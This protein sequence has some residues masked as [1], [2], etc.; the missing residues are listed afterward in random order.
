MVRTTS[1]SIVNGGGSGNQI[2][3][4]QNTTA[5]MIWNGSDWTAAGASSSTTLQSAYDNT[6][7]SAGGA[8]LIVSSGGNTNG[9][10]IRDST[11]NPV[12]GRLLTVQTSS[13]ADFI[14]VNSNVTEYA[15]D[16]G[17]EVA[18]ASSS[19]FPGSTWS[20]ISGATVS[21]YTTAGDNIATGQGS[22]SG[23][24]KYECWKRCQ[25]RAHEHTN[26]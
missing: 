25:E 13:A 6:L 14:S 4:R 7:Q 18:G 24:H 3:M 5:T 2:A 12:N 10:T 22:V 11:V 21:R 19:T 16:A 26:R 15:S 20:A 9:L 17:A 1:H 8:E 23:C